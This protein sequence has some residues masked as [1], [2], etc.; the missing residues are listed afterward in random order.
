ML[1]H[2]R[3]Q[4]HNNNHTNNSSNSIYEFCG[5][6]KA[7]MIAGILSGSHTLS[8]TTF[9]WMQPHYLKWNVWLR[10]KSTQAKRLVQ[11]VLT[12]VTSCFNLTFLL[13]WMLLQNNQHKLTLSMKPDDKYSE[14]QAQM[15][16]EKLQQKVS[17]L[18]L[19]D[20]QQIYDKGQTL[21]FVPGCSLA[22][23]QPRWTS[24]WGCSCRQV[25]F[26][27]TGIC[28][29]PAKFCIGCYELRADRM[30]AVLCKFTHCC[31]AG[32]AGVVEMRQL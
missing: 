6:Y 31:W 15:E 11:H 14:K 18:S 29:A 19:E 23:A 13:L 21:S 8:K 27:P 26:P 10:T 7:G 28:W 4:H 20:K 3:L 12:L 1:I 22:F 2:L 17:A 32:K 25:L 9:G 30:D 24:Y 5:F 16:T